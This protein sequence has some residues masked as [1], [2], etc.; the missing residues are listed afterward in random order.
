MGHFRTDLAFVWLHLAKSIRFGKDHRHPSKRT[1]QAHLP[2]NVYVCVCIKIN[3]FSLDSQS[4]SGCIHLFT[5]SIYDFI[6][7][8]TAADCGDHVVVI[9]TGKIAMPGDE[10]LKR[11]Y[12]EH[13]GFAGGGL[14]TLAYELHE[15]DKTKVQWNKKTTDWARLLR[16]LQESGSFCY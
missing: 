7:N 14:W 4:I 12:F 8:C 3:N 6:L 13:T 11:V 1:A 15:K 16:Y 9:N 10:W 5:H 2:S